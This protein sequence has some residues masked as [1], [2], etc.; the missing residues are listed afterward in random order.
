[1]NTQQVKVTF[2]RVEEFI[3]TALSYTRRAKKKTKIHIAIDIVFPSIKK[4]LNKKNS[5]INKLRPDFASCD[6]KGNLILNEG[7]NGDDRYTFTP[8]KLKQFQEKV[9]E[10]AK[11]EI[12]INKYIPSHIPKDLSYEEVEAFRGIILPDDYEFIEPEIDD[13]E[14]PKEPLVKDFVAETLKAAKSKKTKK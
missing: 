9:E 2:D 6:D 5:L 4:A 8:E 1:M 11:E 10:L 12:K 14:K 7:K 3:D 13:E